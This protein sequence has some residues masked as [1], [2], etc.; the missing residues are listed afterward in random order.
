MHNILYNL[1]FPPLEPTVTMLRLMANHTSLSLYSL[2][3][4]CWFTS[5]QI[6]VWVC[7]IIVIVIWL[8]SLIAY[9]VCCSLSTHIHNT[10]Q[11]THIT[12]RCCY[13]VCNYRF[14][15]QAPTSRDKLYIHKNR[16]GQIQQA[17]H[18][19]CSIPSRLHYL[20]GRR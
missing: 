8:Y 11:R 18:K 3:S 20:L 2:T 13:S 12:K 5:D 17:P 15:Q 9:A 14:P 7:L 1:I 6:F 19:S 16:A 4:S 10:S